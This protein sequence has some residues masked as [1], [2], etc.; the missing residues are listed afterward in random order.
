[1]LRQTEY[2]TFGWII[3]CFI[4][5][6]MSLKQR[7][8]QIKKTGRQSLKHLHWNYVTG[9]CFTSYEYFVTIR[10]PEWFS[11]SPCVMMP[12]QCWCVSH[13]FSHPIMWR[14]VIWEPKIRKFASYGTSRFITTIT[15]S[16]H[17]VL[18]RTRIIHC[19]S[20]H[21]ISLRSTLGFRHVPR[22]SNRNA[23]TAEAKVK[24]SL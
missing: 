2:C 6:L 11:S 1:M 10:F 24:L 21:H 14:K 4:R 5:S 13:F 17:W 23:V 7:A 3:H 19:R 15:R 9:I 8:Y 22:C 12:G 18:S 20:S 16:R